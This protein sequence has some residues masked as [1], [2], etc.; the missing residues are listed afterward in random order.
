VIDRARSAVFVATLVLLPCTAGA[1][2][3]LEE[4][5]GRYKD[6]AVERIVESHDFSLALGAG[7]LFL[8]Q[9]TLR[10]ARKLLAEWGREAELGP[11][12]NARAPQW[13]AAE[14]ALVARA[15][16]ISARRFDDGAWLKEAWSARSAELLSGEEADVVARHFATEGGRMQRML[17][18]W[19]M[20]ET[21]LFIYTFTDRIQYD[22]QGAEKE[23][24]ALQQVAQARIP[25]EDI[26]FAT[27]Y[28]EAF[29]FVAYGPGLK[30]LKMLAIPLTGDIWQR[31]DE[32]GREIETE[33]RRLRPLA[34]PPM[35]AF[36]RGS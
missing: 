14:A 9:N 26:E 30:Y 13:R 2:P 18:D 12:W 24:R 31:I 7:R 22:V 1:Q 29:N 10:A 15:G 25:T 5:R 27:K 4:E 3:T 35:Q 21:V 36:R 28:P 8:K 11:G 16:E 6:E 17:L 19:Y 33:L 32:V 34:E 20:G 23:M